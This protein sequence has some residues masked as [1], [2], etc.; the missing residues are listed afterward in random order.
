MVSLI[1][2]ILIP[3]IELVLGL[4]GST[5]GIMICVIFPAT[6]FICLTEKNT[7]ERILAQIMLVIGIGVMVLGTYANLYAIDHIEPIPN[8]EKLTSSGVSVNINIKENDINNIGNL[9]IDKEMQIKIPDAIKEI[10]HEPV[11]PE[12]PIEIENKPKDEVNEVKA[13]D[14]LQ[15][16]ETVPK[17]EEETLVEPIKVEERKEIPGEDIENKEIKLDD[18][19]ELKESVA[20]V[21]IE[22]IKKEDQELEKGSNAKENWDAHEQ[23]VQEK[24]KLFEENKKIMEEIKIQQAQQQVN[25]EKLKAVQNIQNIAQKAIEKIV[26]NKMNDT[27]LL[28]KVESENVAEIKNIVKQTDKKEREELKADV[29]DSAAKSNNINASPLSYQLGLQNA[30]VSDKSNAENTINEPKRNASVVDIIAAPPNTEVKKDTDISHVDEIKKVID[31]EI[32]KK[33]FT[34][35]LI[36]PKK[37]QVVEEIKD[38]GEK[39]KVADV[40]AP[41]VKESKDNKQE[42]VNPVD[43]KGNEDGGH[44]NDDNLELR[45][46]ILSV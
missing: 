3:N 17:K 5:I 39:T 4:V 45:R 18:K 14:H 16:V 36:R 26:D 29:A 8:Y 35:F 33:N 24:K 7:N 10:R 31:I 11:Q 6:C 37:L 12:E 38:N 2:G 41:I 28:Q 30:K 34:E 44:K 32:L 9:G 27:K 43:V 20:E 1:I 22:A 46:D 19:K 40:E 21:D 42:A 13:E 23:L 15:K 25:A